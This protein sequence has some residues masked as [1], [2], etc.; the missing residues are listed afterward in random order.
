MFQ[1]PKH[2]EEDEDEL[3]YGRAENQ[4]NIT[5]GNN[6]S[7]NTHL[8]QLIS[9][10]I[11]PIST[12]ILC[13]MNLKT[14]SFCVFAIER[15]WL[16]I[17]VEIISENRSGFDKEW[18]EMVLG[19][20]LCPISADWYQRMVCAVAV[21]FVVCYFLWSIVQNWMRSESNGQ[22]TNTP[23]PDQCLLGMADIWNWMERIYTQSWHWVRYIGIPKNIDTDN[24]HIHKY[25]HFAGATKWE[26]NRKQMH[27]YIC[28]A[29]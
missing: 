1:R 2:I 26:L 3:F 11:T 18:V 17:V 14:F 9:V 12:G 8:R 16:Q 6:S 28:I 22:P 27:S 24:T 5:I 20:C 29:P 19:W 25:S 15:N 7:I 10:E 13:E 4:R 21:L 23:S